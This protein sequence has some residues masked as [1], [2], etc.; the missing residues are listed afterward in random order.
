LTHEIRER[1]RFRFVARALGCGGLAFEDAR[2]DMLAEPMAAR[3]KA[4]TEEYFER[5]KIEEEGSR[6]L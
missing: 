2:P 6:S 4:L 1:E 5:E 3:E